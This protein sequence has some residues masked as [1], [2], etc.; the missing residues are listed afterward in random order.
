MSPA[1][2]ANLALDAEEAKLTIQG[3]KAVS[4]MKEGL[5]LM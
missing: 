3:A 5:R 2:A 4:M 1:R